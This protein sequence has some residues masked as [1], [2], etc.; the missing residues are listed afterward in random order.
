MKIL[1]VQDSLGT[2]GAERS[3]ADLWSYLRDEKTG[4][5]IKI[6]LL[7]HRKEGVEKEVK[8][9]GYDINFLKPG[10]F[11]DHVIQI[12]QIIKEF[13][14]DVVHSV[15]FKAF[16]RVRAVRF[17]SSFYHVESL[18]SCSYDPIRFKDPKMNNFG[19][20]VYKYINRL[21]HGLGTDKFIA[22]SREVKEHSQKHLKI[23]PNK[24]TVIPRGRRINPYLKNKEQ[25]RCEIRRSLGIPKEDLVFVH[26]GRQEYPKGHLELLKGISLIDQKLNQ[27]RVHV[28]FCGRKGKASKAI[29]NYVEENQMATKLH[30]LGHRLDVPEILAGSDV[31]VFPSLYEGLGGALIEAQA[32]GLPIICSKIN[33][34][35]EVVSEGENALMFEIGDYNTLADQILLLANNQKLRS[36]MGEKSIT[37][38]QK[39]FRLE[40]IHERMFKF[41]QKVLS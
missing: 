27:K 10:N 23:P 21:T 19:L 30:W 18:V 25:L 4:V 14:P 28:V 12:K 36:E 24:I 17:F 22:I 9:Q 31:F 37:N 41:Y 39:K 2:G 1:Y 3:N 29:E 15:L 20:T 8:E 33:V 13:K 26:V 40:K 7:E 11:F 5:E 38:F 16:I 6:I 34:F 35:R 32:A